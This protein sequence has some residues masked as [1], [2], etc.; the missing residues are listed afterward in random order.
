MPEYGSLAMSYIEL[1]ELYD[2]L[3]NQ[4]QV[5]AVLKEVDSMSAGEVAEG[6]A[7]ARIRLNH[8]DK[9]G[10]ERILRDLSNRYPEHREVLTQLGDVE[11]DLKQYK[12]ALTSYRSAAGGF[13]GDTR[14]HLSM[15]KELYAM[16]HGHEAVDQCRLSGGVMAQQLGGKVRLRLD[17]KR[18]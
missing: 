7:R 5:D 3:G 18:C 10:A 13:F 14:L 15:A 8:S 6:L 9:Q 12:E 16:G 2:S 1:A 4:E 11:S 17:S